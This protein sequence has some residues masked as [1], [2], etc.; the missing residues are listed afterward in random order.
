MKE[1]ETVYESHARCSVL[2]QP[3]VRGG[4]GGEDGA[5]GTGQWGTGQR[6]TGQ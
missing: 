1:G 5:R 6:G 3:L 2:L 4:G